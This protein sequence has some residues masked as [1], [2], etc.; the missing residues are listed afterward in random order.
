MNKNPR[1]NQ[2]G[3]R[4][5]LAAVAG[6][7]SLP[8]LGFA[9]EAH[10][11]ADGCAG[12]MRSDFN[13]DGRSD[14]LVGDPGA[15]VNGQARA[16][17][18]VVLYG[19][20]D[21]LVGEGARDVLWQGEA[22]VAGV[23][24]AGDQFGYAIATADINCDGY[25]D[26]V[27]GTPFEDLSGQ[28]DSG[29]VQVIWGAASGLGTG[30]ASTQYTQAGFGQPIVAGDQFGYA[31]DLVEDLGQGGTPAPDAYALA[32][33]V[34]GANVNGHNDAGALAV[35][36]AYD[37]G[38]ETF[39]ITQDTPGVVGAAEAGDRFGA[40][41]ACGY[42][43]SPTSV[44][45]TVDCAVGAPREDIGS[46]A[47]AG[48]VT[49]VEEIYYSDELSSYAIGQ[50]AAGVPGKAEKGDLYGTTLDVVRVG[51]TSR[52]AVGA[53]GE[54]I[55]SDANA[56]LVQLFSFNGRTMSIGSS[57]TQDTA[58][59]ADSSEPGD[60]FGASLAWI[61]PGLGDTRTRLAVGVPGEK[62]NGY[63]D[64]GQVQVFRIDSLGSEST[65]TQ[66]STGFLSGA[67]KNDRFGERVATVFG[68][69]ERVLLIGSP[70]DTTYATGLVHVVPFG[71]GTVRAWRPGAGGIPAAGA[72]RFGG[73]LA[74]VP[75]GTT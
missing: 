1:V 69:S 35:R 66:D 8:P 59:V 4:L 62:V 45:S 60:E 50:D 36:A 64:A 73:S 30:A 49:I 18:I 22:N 68:A 40:S 31:V 61:A 37:G 71:G 38:S 41:V 55:G 56:G 26:A 63:E 10:A 75:G 72:A 12:G 51:S 3:R 16:G 27:V 52:L 67:R 28:A 23:A 43:S 5:R 11:V 39:W 65:Y 9:T 44:T 42:L 2:R 29:Y 48:A 53:P 70:T 17:R 54:D 13:G 24:E 15:T 34:P 33:G 7:L 6:L 25:T 20:A 57:L 21:L 32:I 14:A 47:D 58:G 19:D 46:Q 74:G